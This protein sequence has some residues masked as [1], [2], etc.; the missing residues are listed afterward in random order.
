MSEIR[1]FNRSAVKDHALKCS[2]EKRAGKFTRVGE[3]F[4]AELEADIEV[5]L[6]EP[7]AKAFVDNSELVQPAEGTRFITG[8]LLERLGESLNAAIPRMIQKK[9]ARQPSCGCTLGR[10]R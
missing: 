6:R 9:V 5:L 7:L 10:T 8:E 1:L 3:D 2:K 4:I